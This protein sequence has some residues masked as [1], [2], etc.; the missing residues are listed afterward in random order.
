M[1]PVTTR[2]RLAR[3]LVGTG[4]EL[5][6]GHN[7][8]VLSLPGTYV[9]YVDRWEPWEN[10][11]LFPELDQPSFPEPDVIADFDRDRLSAL[12]DESQD[13]V[14]CSHVLEHLADPLG[15][16]SEIF[17]VLRRGGVGLLLLP[18]RH[19]TFD[20]GREAT[21]LMHLVADH[22]AGT[23]EVA[24]EHIIEFLEMTDTTAP[25]ARPRDEQARREIFEW[26]RRRSIH[27]HCWDEEEFFEVLVYCVQHLG[28]RWDLVEGL[29]TDDGGSAS[30]E[31]GY[32]LRKFDV[33][34]PDE[35]VASRFIEA[36]RAWR[37]QRGPQRGAADDASPETEEP[38]RRDVQL[39]VL[40]DEIA[41]LNEELRRANDVARAKSEELAA[42]LATKTF[43]YSRG[44][45]HLYAMMRVLGR[46]RRHRGGDRYSAPRE[47][48]SLSA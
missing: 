38:D 24:D 27:V 33:A 17:R 31:F 19:R 12:G 41:R 22:R 42:L 35:V 26:H 16:L 28:H 44:L 6:P 15:F 11:R 9:R 36:G 8:F 13:F 7:P 45:R 40:G 20:S 39:S 4:V 29:A 2:N 37:A 3:H 10:R 25:E 30:I 5:G 32:V 48:H 21:P 47:T 18:D 23:T 1:D 14:I 34:L 43:R 46:P